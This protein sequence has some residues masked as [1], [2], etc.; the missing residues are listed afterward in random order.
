M[1]LSEERSCHRWAY[2]TF[3]GVDCGDR[4]RS[5][6][7]VAITRAVAKRPAGTV[8][9]V[10]DDSADRE[11]AYRWLSNGEVSAAQ[12]TAGLGEHTAQ[13]C[14]GHG[15]MYIPI[16]G[17]SL[18][19]TDRKQSRGVGGVGAWKDFGRGLHVVTAL[20]VDDQGVPLGVLG[21]TWWAR[22]QRSPQRRCS[23]RKL[24]QKETRY[25]VETLEQACQQ[26]RVH[27][28]DTLAI[29][30]MDRGFDCWPVLRMADEGA[31]FIVRAR[32]DRRLADSSA[33]ER[34]YLV[35]SLKSR[36]IR[37]HYTVQV[38]ERPGRPARVAQMQVQ[39]QRVVIELRVSKR[40]RQYVALNAVL[41]REVGR[42]RGT[43]LSW[44]LLTTEPVDTFAQV[45]DVVR[46]YA[47]RWRIEEMHRAWKRGACNVEDTQ[48]RSREATIKWATI[49]AAVAT[50]AVRLALLAR[51]TPEISAAQEF[52]QTEIDA[53]ILLRRK[54]TKFKPGDLP[55]LGDVVRLIADL[56]GYTGMSS[57][58]PPGATV[59]SRGLERLGMA[60]EI[61]HTLQNK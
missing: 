22:T 57:G 18:S 37:G 29:A 26:L 45:V 21:Q 32:S 20:A 4:R 30:V 14:V 55:S 44:M 2:R 6:R 61:L 34:R 52:S 3:G 1:S 36:P 48:L 25:L 51:T 31:H 10:F 49:H 39:T 41:A 43:S 58:G 13:E 5:R 60:A 12:L 56:G 53:V 17:S 35:G 9:E 8:T 23:R 16:D 46:G 19:L 54:R 38:P 24:A 59:I 11:G 47:C 42:P 15:R 33:G 28:P 50:R 40:R 7:L 27:A